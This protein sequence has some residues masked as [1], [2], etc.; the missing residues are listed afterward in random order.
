MAAAEERQTSAVQQCR[1]EASD[2]L[3]SATEA[4][5]KFHSHVVSQLQDEASRDLYAETSWVVKQEKHQALSE[6]NG[7]YKINVTNPRKKMK[8]KS[9]IFGRWRENK[10]VSRLVGIATDW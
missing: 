5:T 9:G 10:D 1:K 2:G 6:R 3:V 7:V 8:H 4:L